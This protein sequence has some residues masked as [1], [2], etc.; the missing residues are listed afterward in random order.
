MEEQPRTFK[1]NEGGLI[2][3]KELVAQRLRGKTYRLQEVEKRGEITAKLRELFTEVY[4]LVTEY[5]SDDVPD[6]I[7]KKASAWGTLRKHDGA[8]RHEIPLPSSN[9]PQAKQTHVV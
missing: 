2:S 9:S 7:C 5:F 3:G 4:M 6:Q 1:G 8:S